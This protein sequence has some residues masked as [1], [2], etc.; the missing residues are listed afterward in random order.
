ML[1]SALFCFSSFAFAQTGELK[2]G[3]ENKSGT[4]KPYKILT[5][6][7]QFTIQSTQNIKS[8]MVWTASGHRIIE[9]K[10]INSTSCS[11]NVLINEKIFFLMIEFENGKRNTEKIGTK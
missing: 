8:L 4:V 6:G 5:S 3:I 9:Q 11:F 1:F 2:A 7:K 10:E